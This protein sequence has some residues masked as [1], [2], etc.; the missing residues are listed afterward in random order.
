MIKIAKLILAIFML[1][2]WNIGLANPLDKQINNLISQKFNYKV[3]D[4]VIT[5]PTAKPKLDCNTPVLSLLNKKKQWG[6]MTI[7]AQCDNKKKFIQIHVAVIGNYIVA[8]QTIHAG[9][10]INK[11]DIRIQSGRLDKISS[12]VVVNE[13]DALNHI[14]LRNINQ[15]EPIRTTMLQNNWLVKAGQIIKVIIRGGGYEVATSGKTLGN[16]ALNE[17]IRVK[18]N[19]NKIVEGTLTHQGVIIFNK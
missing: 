16:A 18:L 5:Y 6:N 3:D 2:S 10:V 12:A 8:K 1:F 9:T 19:S 15:D 11:D 4:V 7:S 17:K 14:A 13:V